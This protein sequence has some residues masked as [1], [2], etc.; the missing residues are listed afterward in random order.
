MENNSVFDG[1]HSKYVGGVDLNVHSSAFRGVFNRPPGSLRVLE[2]PSLDEIVNAFMAGGQVVVKFVDSVVVKP[3]SVSD[4]S[5]GFASVVQSDLGAFSYVAEV[6]E[7]VTVERVFVKSVESSLWS[8]VS[9]VARKRAGLGNVF[10]KAELV[11]VVD[12]LDRFSSFKEETEIILGFDGELFVTLP[13]S[14]GVVS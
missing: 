11:S 6:V 1:L 3:V 14:K 2:A 12:V 9:G 5:S 10:W 7:H 13:G 4:A 8:D